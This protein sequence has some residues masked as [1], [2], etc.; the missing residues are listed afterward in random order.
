MQYLVKQ[1][2]TQNFIQT[3]VTILVSK[4]QGFKVRNFKV[5]NFNFFLLYS[6]KGQVKA[7]IIGIVRME[8][9]V[10]KWKNDKKTMHSITIE[11]LIL[12]L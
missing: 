9:P 8:F 1:S 2:R 11:M 3:E 4:F 10:F 7:P 5:R 12:H 6:P